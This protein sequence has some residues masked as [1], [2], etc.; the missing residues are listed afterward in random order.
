VLTVEDAI[1]KMTSLPAQILRLRDRGQ[2]RE[3]FV[4]D[5]VVF[6]PETV[7]ATNSFESP[8]SYPTGVPYVVVNGV[9]VVDG[10]EHTGARPGRALR[11]PAWR[12]DAAAGP[13]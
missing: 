9:V 12:G 3:G 11:G 1:R 4:A 10:N 8:K 7:G 2:V 6:D 5:L 13:L